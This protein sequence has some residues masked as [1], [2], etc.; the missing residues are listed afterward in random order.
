MH[1]WPLL[2]GPPVCVNSVRIGGQV[3][4]KVASLLENELNV[5]AMGQRVWN[6]PGLGPIGVWVN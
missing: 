5:R 3:H 4:V 1:P 2:L 6:F